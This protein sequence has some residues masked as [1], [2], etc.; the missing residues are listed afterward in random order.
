ML[1]G[2]NSSHPSSSKSAN[3]AQSHDVRSL[4]ALAMAARKILSL[5][6]L[7]PVSTFAR[8]GF[9]SCMLCIGSADMHVFIFVT[10]GLYRFGL[11]FC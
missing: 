9:A 6:F 3:R 5:V 10:H 11:S 4:L 1:D 7:F 8:L 2:C